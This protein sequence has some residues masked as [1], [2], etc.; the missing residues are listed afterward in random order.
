M[1]RKLAM[2][3][4]LLATPVAA[5]DFS[6]GSEAKSWN[7]YA[8]VPAKFEARVVDVLC[9]LTGD[10]PDNCGAGTRQ[11][12]L[13][14]TADDV[15]VLA[16]KN[17]QPAFTGAAEE[18][19][20]FCNEVVEVDGLLLEDDELGARNVYLVQ[21]IKAA[22]ADWIKANTWTKKWA[23]KHPEA[24]GKGPWFRR[25]PRV[26]EITGREGYL[27]LGLEEDATYAE[28]NF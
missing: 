6:E 11:M 9:E 1:M 17:S 19:A 22:D 12:G 28:E 16:M 10:C 7:L 27:G 2:L 15:L 4:A 3:A 26:K 13:V 23:A 25:D 14:R 20:P 18:L 5:Q 21:R 8:E 24:K